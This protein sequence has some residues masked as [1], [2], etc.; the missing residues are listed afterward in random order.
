MSVNVY[1][2]YII[3]QHL[4]IFPAFSTLISSSV[5]A[6]METAAL[7]DAELWIEADALSKSR[8]RVAKENFWSRVQVEGSS[9]L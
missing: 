4:V 6:A 3:M 2:Q 9:Q 7:I 8:E 5:I 1:T